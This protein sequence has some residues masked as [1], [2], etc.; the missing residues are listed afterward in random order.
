MGR[1]YGRIKSAFWAND[2]IKSCLP[3]TKMVAI[4]FL[5]SAH[6]NAIGCFRL[7][8][9]YVSYDTN[10]TEDELEPVFRELVG[11][12]FMQWCGQSPWVWVPNFLKHN[13]PENAN[14][15]RKCAKELRSVPAGHASAAIAVELANI[16]REPRMAFHPEKNKTGVKDEEISALEPY[17]NGIETVS[18]GLVPLPCPIP[19]PI[20]SLIPF[21]IVNGGS[22]ALEEKS[23]DKPEW[24]PKRDRYDRVLGELS[25]K[26]IFD[27][28]KVIL[29]KNA[30]GQVQRLLKCYNHCLRSVACMLMQ[31]DDKSNP[32]EWFAG[33]L[34]RSELD[35]RPDPKHVI[36]PESEY[37]SED[38]GR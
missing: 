30:G 16:A 17:R 36:F 21:T 20:H 23:T 5:T 13:R 24:W 29:G 26:L 2:D 4:Y 28:G 27:M 12:N 8:V 10:L 15:W 33:V 3:T 9:A 7:P 22:A 38:R 32:R 35:E 31:A 25:D 19:N 34:K 1:E 37:R 11:V 6:T 18:E 14:V